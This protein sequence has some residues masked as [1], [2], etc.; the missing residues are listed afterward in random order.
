MRRRAEE[1]DLGINAEEARLKY[2]AEYQAILKAEEE[3]QISEEE[4][5]KPEEHKFTR[6]KVGEDF[7]LSLEVIHQSE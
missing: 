2:E 5:L 6:P 3:D 7:L 4:K 1:E